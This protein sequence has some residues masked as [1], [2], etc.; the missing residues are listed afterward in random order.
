MQESDKRGETKD[1]GTLSAH[2]SQDVAQNAALNLTATREVI[3]LITH[4][5]AALDIPVP[6][7]RWP[8]VIV[9]ESAKL[10]SYSV[11]DNSI[12]IAKRHLND[13]ATYAEEA[14]HFLKGIISPPPKAD[15]TNSSEMEDYKIIQDFCGRL[16][17]DFAKRICMGSELE[18]LFVGTSKDDGAILT[19]VTHGTAERA[20]RIPP[21]IER[22]IQSMRASAALF[23]D[24]RDRIDRILNEE[25]QA[26]TLELPRATTLLKHEIAN[27]IQSANTPALAVERFTQIRDFVDQKMALT[28]HEI[29]R[30]LDVLRT[31]GNAAEDCASRISRDCG[32]TPLAIS[33]VENHTRG[34]SSAEELMR[35]HP[36]TWP[37]QFKQ[38]MHL[39]V[40]ETR[41]P[42]GYL[43]PL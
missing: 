31:S 27:V 19:G 5:A 7:E 6:E 8:T 4:L 2:P 9:N 20:E 39:S 35:T 30:V 18:H 28:Q 25:W 22:E 3:S 1:G 24:L 34:Y 38:I 36:D 37:E 42:E 12:T 21:E 15:E 26:N 32:L 11:D 41:N 23:H 13:G 40:I 16:G 10:S 43:A 17:R 29:S 14:T 33:D